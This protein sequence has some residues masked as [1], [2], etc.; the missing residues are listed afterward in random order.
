MII[1]GWKWRTLSALFPFFG[2]QHGARIHSESTTQ[3]V[4]LADAMSAGETLL[5][6]GF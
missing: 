2:G 5:R 1:P 4:V 3:D 6:D